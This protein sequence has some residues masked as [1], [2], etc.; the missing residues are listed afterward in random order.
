M[1]GR[2]DR[3]DGAAIG[4]M[5]PRLEWSRDQRE[6]WC[7]CWAATVRER[8]CCCWAATVRDRWCRFRAATAR[9]RALRRAGPPACLCAALKHIGATTAFLSHDREGVDALPVAGLHVRVCA[10]PPG[11]AV[12]RDCRRSG[13]VLIGAVHTASS[14][15]GSITWSSS[16]TR[17]RIRNAE[18]MSGARRERKSRE[19]GDEGTAHSPFAA[20]MRDSGG[21]RYA[22]SAPVS[23]GSSGNWPCTWRRLRRKAC[24]SPPAR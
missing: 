16:A 12:W 4:W 15:H 11:P 5:E 18:Q 10:G 7:C 14:G 1:R 8:W 20:L 9:E 23:R 13:C 2:F 24:C 22:R 3:S 21:D 17:S 19:G 6:R